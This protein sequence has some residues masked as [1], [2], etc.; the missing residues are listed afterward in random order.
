MFRPKTTQEPS[1]SDLSNG[2]DEGWTYEMTLDDKDA[3]TACLMFGRLRPGGGRYRQ[4]FMNQEASRPEL[5][6]AL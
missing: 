2:T 4:H 5:S 3:A 1:Y 6:L